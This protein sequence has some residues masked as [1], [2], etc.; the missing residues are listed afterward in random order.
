M[1]ATRSLVRALALLVILGPLPA[2]GQAAAQAAT[3][4]DLV[5]A[6]SA[7]EN[8]S[9]PSSVKAQVQARID[10]SSENFLRYLSGALADR[11]SDPLLLLRV[12]KARPLPESFEPND[13]VSLDGSGLSL[14]RP[15]LSL[16]R[17]AFLALKEMSA[18]ARAEGVT[19]LVSSSYRSYSYQVEVF[20]RGVATDGLAETEASVARPGHSQHQLGTAVDFGSIT[21]AFAQT[22]ASRW[23][24]ANSRRFGFSL[25]FP[26]GMTA[27]TGYKW[28][29]WHYRYIGKAAAALEGEYFGGV[30]EYVL[31]FIEG[32]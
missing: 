20:N 11:G 8:S 12:G 1:L 19:L 2:G 32:M 18:A 14:S 6:R 27:V 30:Q 3:K 16:R 7:L 28:E 9:L 23:L 29:S 10:A 5:S 31:A 4:L 26:K 21:D 13:L 24:A 17:A 25:S 22:K 15:G